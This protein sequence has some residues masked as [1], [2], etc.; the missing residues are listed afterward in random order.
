M[1]AALMFI[2]VWPPMGLSKSIVLPLDPMTTTPW[3]FSALPLAE[4][5]ICFIML[6]IF[7]Y[8]NTMKVK[9]NKKDQCV[10][11]LLSQI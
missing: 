10:V 4:K 1:S 9:V 11:G 8:N 2:W 3:M 7:Y 6:S 5:E